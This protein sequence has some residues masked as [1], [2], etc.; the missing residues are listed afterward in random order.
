MFRKKCLLYNALYCYIKDFWSAIIFFL[1]KFQSFNTKREKEVTTT[2]LHQF[3]SSTLFSFLETFTLV[4]IIVPCV[5]ICI[6]FAWNCRHRHPLLF[7]QRANKSPLQKVLSW[8]K[9]MT[10]H[11]HRWLNSSF[12]STLP[13]NFEYVGV[14]CVVAVADYIL[15]R[16]D[17]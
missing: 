15:C 5:Q 4:M 6:F 12:P 8:L 14:L 3:L 16:L 11:H 1:Q 7:Q 2:H 9:K 13:A 17:A 10:A